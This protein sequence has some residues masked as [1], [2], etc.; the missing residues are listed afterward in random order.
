MTTIIGLLHE[1]RV[2]SNIIDS[3]LTVEE[4]LKLVDPHIKVW[5]VTFRSAISAG[6]PLSMTLNHSACSL[7]SFDVSSDDRMKFVRDI[8]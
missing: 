5:N 1:L 4:F 2:G 3:N 8:S 7:L 6:Q